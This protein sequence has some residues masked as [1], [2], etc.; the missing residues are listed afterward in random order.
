M[1][2][3]LRISDKND[4]V[5]IEPKFHRWIFETWADDLVRDFEQ[6]LLGVGTKAS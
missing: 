1:T 4:D 6:R 2:G 3:L 5:E